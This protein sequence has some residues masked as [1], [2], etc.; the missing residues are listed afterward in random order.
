[1]ILVNID[2]ALAVIAVQDRIPELAYFVQQI[3]NGTAL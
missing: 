1:M 2:V 3:I